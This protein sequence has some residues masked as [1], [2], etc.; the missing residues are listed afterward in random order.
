MT[1]LIRRL[2]K[3]LAMTIMVVVCLAVFVNSYVRADGNI[4]LGLSVD[5]TNLYAGEVVNLTVNVTNMADIMEFGPIEIN[6]DMTKMAYG[7]F[8]MSEVASQYF[9]FMLEDGTTDGLILVSGSND[10][11]INEENANSTDRDYEPTSPVINETG[12][13]ALCTISF[14]VLDN[15]TGDAR[16]WIGNATGFHDTNGQAVTCVVED[17]ITTTIVPTVSNDATLAMIRVGGATLSPEFESFTYAYTASVNR[18][19]TDVI[20]SATPSNLGASYSITGGSNLVIGDNLISINVTSQDGTVHQ[21]YTVILTRRE[22]Y[23]PEGAFLITVDGNE[24]NFAN[25][26]DSTVIPAGFTQTTRQINGYSVPVYIKDGVEC[27]LAYLSTSET[28][29]TLYFYNVTTREITPYNSATTIILEG[30]ILN[31]ATVPALVVIPDGFDEQNR[32]IGDKVLNGYANSTGDFI[33]YFVDDEG[34]GDFYIYDTT[35]GTFTKFV[36]QDQ[37]MKYVYNILFYVFMGIS[38]IEAG[39]IAIIV[40]SVKK[41]RKERV[42]PRPKRV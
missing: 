37:T 38:V 34:R 36:Q 3:L 28:E 6:Y 18:D 31:P 30:A 1:K 24:M 35:T 41:I 29:P 7:T 2:E 42:N 9:E 22:G 20:V 26:S 21:T 4:T 17:G 11:Y 25:I 15:S 8:E 13:I 40:T 16:F 10:A 23:V 19:I 32:T 14:R 5:N 39:M 27:V 33:C 12:T